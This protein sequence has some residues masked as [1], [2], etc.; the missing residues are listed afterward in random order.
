MDL[1]KFNET[2]LPILQVLSN[3]ETITGRELV[4]L[5][6]K[7]FYSHLAED[8]LGQL[9]K[10]G[11]RLIEN[12]ITWGK[13]YLKKGGLVHYPQRGTVQ[14]TAKGKDTKAENLSLEQMHANVISFYEPEN[15]PVKTTQEIST[16]SPQD[17]IDRGIEQIER[18]IKAEL[19]EKLKV[20]DP[21]SFEKIILILLKKMGYG[22]FIETS[23]SRDGGIDGI[24]NEDQLGLERIYIQAKRY[25]ENKVRET[26]I[27]DFIGAM[28][29]DTRNGI[30][31]TTSKFDEK[32]QKKARE[33]HH[34]IILVDGIKLV[35]LMHRYSVGVQVKSSY[36]VK[37][38]DNDFFESE[39]L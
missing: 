10:S 31:V 26:E 32:A 6:E 38:I 23:K 35:E 19:L 37:V 36:E 8:L 30:F 18:S 25:S 14:I 11:D 20:V 33:A 22:D 17:L 15:S 1:P 16:S 39:G 12:R 3:G 27:R 5:V 4:Q 29:G 28:S 2:F 9:T 7:R 13:T 34:K 21:Y 24:I